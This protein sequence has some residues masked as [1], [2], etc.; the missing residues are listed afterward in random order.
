MTLEEQIEAAI[1][2]GSVSAVKELIEQASAPL[3]SQLEEVSVERDRYRGQL[4][5]EK[6]AR[7]FSESAFLADKVSAPADIM[8]A[9]FGKH[10]A[11]AE[12]GEVIAVDSDG[13]P[14][15]SRVNIGKPAGLDE[16]IEAIVNAYPDKD[17]LLKGASVHRHTP[18]EHQAHNGAKTLTRG[19]FDAL[20]ARDRMARM[21]GG[22]RIVDA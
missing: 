5:S 7:A 3:L 4:H 11:V 8:A 15:P 9:M 10:F 6:I 20:G 2:E 12:N 18:S 22:Y 17:A 1:T 19:Q 14:T 13:N 21:K 16:A